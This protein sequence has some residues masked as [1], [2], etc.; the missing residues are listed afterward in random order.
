[1]KYSDRPQILT[2]NR[3]ERLY[4]GG[5]GLDKWQKLEN[6]GD[7]HNSEEFLVSTV[8]YIGPGTPE[9]HGISRAECEGGWLSLDEMIRA[10]EEAFLGAGYFHKT[11]GNLGVLA[12]AGDSARRLIIQSHPTDDFARACLAGIFGKTE[13]WYIL[14]T[15]E[16]TGY[17]YAGIKEGVTKADF[18]QAYQDGNSEAMLEMMHKVEFQKGDMIRIPSGMLHAMGAGATF[19]EFHQPCDYTL[20]YEKNYFGKQISEE[21]L[22][23]GLGSEKLMDSISFTEYSYENLIEIIKPVFSQISEKQGGQVQK[24]LSHEVNRWFRVDRV[25]IHSCMRFVQNAASHC[26]MIAAKENVTL[27]NEKGRWQLLQGRGAVIPAGAGT[28]NI[29]GSGAELLIAYPFAEEGVDYGLF[30]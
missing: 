17:C 28:L 9:N 27:Y 24:L 26:I 10:E 22:H 11:N 13:A 2:L 8:P 16:D 15:R 7:G 6:H 4:L 20:R 3:V 30:I 19:L 29:A 23:C 14:D 1:M 5:S 21:E 12:R 18:V 25:N